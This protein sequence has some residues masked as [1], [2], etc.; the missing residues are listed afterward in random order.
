MA[1]VFF[2]AKPSLS[3]IFERYL[4]HALPDTLTP[5]LRV[6]SGTNFPPSAGD[7]FNL[8]CLAWQRGRG[9]QMSKVQI[10]ASDGPALP[11][12]GI[13][14][15][16]I[17]EGQSGE[18]TVLLFSLPVQLTDN[19]HK[20]TVACSVEFVTGFTPSPQQRNQLSEVTLYAFSKC[21]SPVL[22][23]SARLSL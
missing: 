5:E 13:R 7:T 16:I 6:L 21:L 23:I 12:S 4:V 19:R 1:F 9:S 8:T 2:S 3:D 20:Q 10:R 15:F 11:T 22:P 18:I 17:L 14:S